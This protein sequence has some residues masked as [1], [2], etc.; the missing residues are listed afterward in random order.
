[1]GLLVPGLIAGFVIANMVVGR[2]DERAFRYV[3]VGITLMGGS[4]LLTRELSGL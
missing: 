4:I 3:A 1:M 2:L